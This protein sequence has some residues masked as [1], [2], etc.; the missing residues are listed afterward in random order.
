MRMQG[1]QA[2]I[3][4]EVHLEDEGICQTSWDGGKVGIRRGSP[5]DHVSRDVRCGW[6]VKDQGSG[7]QK[8]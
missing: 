3:E 2:S 7:W 5:K 6:D 8:R 4:N 1:Y